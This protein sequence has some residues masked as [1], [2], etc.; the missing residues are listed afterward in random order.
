MSQS[1]LRGVPIPTVLIIDDDEEMRF[2]LADVLNA[3]G[4]QA[5]TAAGSDEAMR[6]MEGIRPDVIITDALMPGGDG[7]EL[8]R[9]I[10]SDES[11]ERTKVI[12]MTSLYRSPR[13]KY[14]AYRQ[15]KADEYILKPVDFPNLL[16]VLGRLVGRRPERRVA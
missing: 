6:L 5:S 7:R 12:I 4:Y 9:A 2:I 8:C 10:K 1:S 14:E 3:S 11:F 13:Y 16:S 15:F